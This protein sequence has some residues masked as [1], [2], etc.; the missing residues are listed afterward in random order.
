M[1]DLKKGFVVDLHVP[2]FIN[3]V[4]PVT[5]IKVISGVN[6]KPTPFQPLLHFFTRTYTH[7]SGSDS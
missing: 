5:E 7:T 1:M 3:T 2:N 4:H 6:K